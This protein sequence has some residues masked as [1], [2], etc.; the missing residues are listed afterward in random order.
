MKVED[1][2]RSGLV[3]LGVAA[4]ALL[5]YAAAAYSRDPQALRRG[6]ARYLRG[7]AHGLEQA[8]LLAAQAREHLADLWAEAR[9]GALAD[10]DHADF[11][12]QA[13]KAER[14]AS[15]AAAADADAPDA[16]AAR[17]ARPA[18][19]RKRRAAP[20]TPAAAAPAAKKATRRPR[21][22]PAATPAAAR[23]R[24]AAPAPGAAPTDAPG[25]AAPAEAS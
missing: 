21:K 10:V 17:P 2:A 11:E 24:P 7:A 9:D 8:T 4:G 12:R 15:A 19:K 6:A 23:A 20:K 22:T 5:G 16:A 25:K 1:L 14:A 3:V 18:V 13:G